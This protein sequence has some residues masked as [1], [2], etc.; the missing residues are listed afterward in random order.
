MYLDVYNIHIKL[1][2]FVRQES[3][4]VQVGF[5]LLILLLQPF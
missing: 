3:M 5:E 1:I 2:F 4:V